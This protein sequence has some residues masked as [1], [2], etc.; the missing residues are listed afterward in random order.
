MDTYLLHLY[1]GGGRPWMEHV[2]RQDG[3]GG[4]GAVGAADQLSGASARSAGEGGSNHED[5][6]RA[7]HVPVRPTTDGR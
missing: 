4:S 7:A 5:N 2:Q 6:H 1:E 3:E